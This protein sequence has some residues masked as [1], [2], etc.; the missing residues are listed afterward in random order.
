VSGGKAGERP[1]PPQCL[2]PP[3]MPMDVARAFV[4]KACSSDGLLTLRHWRGGWWLWRTSCWIEA[5]DR[6]VRS[7]L[8]RFT[9]NAVYITGD[10]LSLSLWAPTR[11]KIGD[12]LE[13]LAAIL[14]PASRSRPAKLAR[15]PIDRGCRLPRQWFARR[16][17]AA[18]SAS[19]TAVFQPDQRALRLPAGRAGTGPVAS[20]P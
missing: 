9:E 16:R 17:G 14:H 13:A 10:R 4:E 8:Y 19:H 5:E 15:R 12:L 18:A 6:A 11:R 2:P 3:S 20:V 7:L 1:L